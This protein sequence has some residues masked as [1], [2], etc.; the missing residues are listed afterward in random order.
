MIRQIS[1]L[2]KNWI[3]ADPHVSGP[4][5]PLTTRA[6]TQTHMHSYTASHQAVTVL[7]LEWP[8]A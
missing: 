4:F 2:K 5:S 3:R 7:T 6:G 1:I 8:P